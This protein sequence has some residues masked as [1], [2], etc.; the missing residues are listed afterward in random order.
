MPR[1]DALPDDHQATVATTWS[2]SIDAANDTAP[3]HLARPLLAVAALLDPNTIP[4]DLFITTAVTDYLNI[5]RNPG[6]SEPTRPV[7]DRAVRDTLDREPTRPCRDL[8]QTRTL[9]STGSMAPMA[10]PTFGRATRRGRRPGLSTLPTD[11][12]SGDTAGRGIENE[13]SGAGPDQPVSD[14]KILTRRGERQKISRGDVLTVTGRVVTDDRVHMAGSAH[15]LDRG[16]ARSPPSAGVG[17]FTMGRRA[18]DLGDD[19]VA[20]GRG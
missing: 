11:Y 15:A 18:V 19:L 12:H 5:H 3:R 4:S 6:N 7:D 1:P 10:P 8:A 20:A 17:G 13:A 14:A 9:V 2:L 16:D